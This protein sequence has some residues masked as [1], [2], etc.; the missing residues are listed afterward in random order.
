MKYKSVFWINPKIRFLDYFGN[1]SWQY[2]KTAIKIWNFSKYI[3][4]LLFDG[5]LIFTLLGFSEPKVI[6][7]RGKFLRLFVGAACDLEAINFTVD[8]RAS[9]CVFCADWCTHIHTRQRKHCSSGCFV[10]LA[11]TFELEQSQAKHTKPGSAFILI[12]YI[13]GDLLWRNRERATII[14]ILMGCVRFC[15]V[16]RSH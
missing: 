9:T 4:C 10:F 1:F 3:S 14:I 2:P 6:L 12:I 15:R 13:V 11:G 7:H 8:W 5:N 16:P